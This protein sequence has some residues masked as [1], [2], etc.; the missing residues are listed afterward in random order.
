MNR[1]KKLTM[2]LLL[3]VITVCVVL[4][5]QIINGQ[6]EVRILNKTVYWKYNG[7]GSTKITSKQVAELY[8]NS[9]FIGSV[10]NSE[11]YYSKRISDD[12][13]ALFDVVFESNPDICAQMKNIFG[14]GLP[15]YTVS[16]ALTM[17]NNNPIVLNF[18]TV[19]QKTQYGIMEF[20]YEEKTQTLLDFN[21]TCSFYNDEPEFDALELSVTNYYNK[22]GLSSEQFFFQSYLDLPYCYTG[23]GIIQD[24]KEIDEKLNIQL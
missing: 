22:L 15:F 4:V 20:I 7:R 19:S 17:I 13:K 23:F 9:G 10:Y 18:I 11:E 24:Q 6:S 5:P 14:S 21:Y 1:I 16:N 8:Y 2:F 3:A 12:S